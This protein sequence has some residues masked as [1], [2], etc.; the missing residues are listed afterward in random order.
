MQITLPLDHDPMTRLKTRIRWDGLPDAFFKSVHQRLSIA[1]CGQNCLPQYLV[2]KKSPWLVWRVER[3]TRIKRKEF[4]FF[5]IM[6]D[7]R[8]LG[9]RFPI[10]GNEN[11]QRQIQGRK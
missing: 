3:I 8:E 4:D 9:R 6:K 5:D 2:T 10:A 11:H 7:S 1:G